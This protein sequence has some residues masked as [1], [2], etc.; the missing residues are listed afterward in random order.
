M[1]VC[2]C[3]CVCVF[4]GNVLGRDLSIVAMLVYFV[5]DTLS[6]EIHANM[7]RCKTYTIEGFDFLNSCYL[8][9]KRQKNG[10]CKTN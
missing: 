1:C 3:V 5:I 6:S 4:M 8:I 9:I 7:N 10:A 2:V